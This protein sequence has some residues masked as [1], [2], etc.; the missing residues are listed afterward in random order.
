MQI[1]KKHYIKHYLLIFL[2]LLVS[3]CAGAEV[4][5]EPT[6]EELYLEAM[7]EFNKGKALGILSTIDYEL[8]IRKFQKVIDYYPVSNYAVLAEL[9]I[10]DAYFRNREYVK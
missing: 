3:G 8:I 4:K 1:V 9:R 10:A 2:V 5:K 6:A 7:E